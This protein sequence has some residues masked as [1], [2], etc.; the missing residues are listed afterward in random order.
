[1]RMVR[2]M[3]DIKIKVKVWSKEL[4]DRLGIDGMISVVQQ[5]RLWWYGHDDLVKKYMEYE[6]EVPDKEVD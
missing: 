2:W 5:N 6:V 4:R 3:R 1:M